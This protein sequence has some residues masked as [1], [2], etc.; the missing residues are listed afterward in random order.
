MGSGST[1]SGGSCDLGVA[2]GCD[3]R[4]TSKR[5]PIEADLGAEETPEQEGN[6]AGK[7]DLYDSSDAHIHRIA[8]DSSGASASCADEEEKGRNEVV[9]LQ[10]ALYMKDKK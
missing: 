10:N 1:D 6:A 7:Y 5:L 4:V 2:L 9:S 8:T 3:I